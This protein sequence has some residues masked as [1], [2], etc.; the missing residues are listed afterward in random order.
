L[1]DWLEAIIL[2]EVEDEV[3]FLKAVF[4]F[5]GGNVSDLANSP[6]FFFKQVVMALEIDEGEGD[7]FWL[8][9]LNEHAN[10]EIRQLCIL[11]YP[12]TAHLHNISVL[13]P[14]EACGRLLINDA[15]RTEK[16]RTHLTLEVIS[17]VAVMRIGK[18]ARTTY[19]GFCIR[20]H[21]SL[22]WTAL[23]LRSLPRFEELLF[24]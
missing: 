1:G 16:E 19:E 18:F 17:K 2:F 12:I 7:W 4:A 23:M 20:Y 21:G 13:F 8:L 10:A 11:F 5:L 3:V 6:I 9:G 22:I 14:E 15:P 24:D